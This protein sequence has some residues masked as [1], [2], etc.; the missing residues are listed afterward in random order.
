[1]NKE[2]TTTLSVGLAA[3]ALLAL[4]VMHR[5]SKQNKPP[6]VRSPGSKPWRMSQWVRHNGILRT[7]GLVGDFAKI[8]GS[9]TAEQTAEALG[10]LDDILQQAG[11]ERRHLLSVTIF[12]ADYDKNFDEM[13]AVCD[14]WIAEKKGEGDDEGS[15]TRIC[16]Q[17]Y[18]GKGFEIELQAEAHYE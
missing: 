7:Q 8:P 18:L 4:F 2:S 5:T 14:K 16:V 11:L 1:M 9:S 13:N 17:A 3:G 10:K 15:P 6:P 12:I